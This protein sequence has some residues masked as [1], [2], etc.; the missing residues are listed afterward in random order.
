[1][2]KQKHP[3]KDNRSADHLGTCWPFRLCADVAR[4]SRSPFLAP[5]WYVERARP[6]ASIV[7]AADT[8]Q[9]R[10]TSNWP[11]GPLVNQQINHLCTSAY[12]DLL[13]SFDGRSVRLV[14]DRLIVRWRFYVLSAIELSA[15]SLSLSMP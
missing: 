10:T 3:G 1:M 5:R 4:A 2:Q 15:L 13:D 11:K 6:C 14:D 7:V 8:R 12:F 9:G